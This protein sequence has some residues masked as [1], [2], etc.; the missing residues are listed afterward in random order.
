MR[1]KG[2]ETTAVG[3][4]EV[5]EMFVLVQSCHKDDACT[6]VVLLA[7]FSGFLPIKGL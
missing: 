5:G 4:K 7:T 1:S 3:R 2:K 6:E